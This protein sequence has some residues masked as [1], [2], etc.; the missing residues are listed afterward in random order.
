MGA[1]V[2][3]LRGAQIEAAD[4]STETGDAVLGAML[5][6]AAAVIVVAC[7]AVV[8]AAYLRLRTCTGFLLAVYVLGVGEIVVLTEA[9]SIFHWVGELGYIIG[10]VVLLAVALL[11]WNRVGRPA[12]PSPS[13]PESFARI[14]HSFSWRCRQYRRLLPGVSGYRYAAQCLG[15]VRV[16]PCESRGVAPAGGGGVLPDTLT[17]CECHATQRGDV[18]AVHVCVRQPGYIRCR[19]PTS[20]RGGR[21]ARRVRDRDPPWVLKVGVGFR[22]PAHG[23]PVDRGSPIGDH[24]E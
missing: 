13:P 21:G 18:D 2:D 24:T 4:G 6:L 9:L 7:T 1:L 11:V 22:G 14:L 20:R 5:A 12:G 15:F 17:E 23:D 10:E 3:G 8:A 19:T 16:P